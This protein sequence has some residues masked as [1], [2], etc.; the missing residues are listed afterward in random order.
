M[1]TKLRMPQTA[2]LRR[3]VEFQHGKQG[4]ARMLRR[5]LHGAKNWVLEDDADGMPRPASSKAVRVFIVLIPVWLVVSA[6]TGGPQRGGRDVGMGQAVLMALVLTLVGLAWLSARER[7]L[8]REEPWA[9]L[10]GAETEITE[11]DTDAIE[12]PVGPESEAPTDVFEKSQVEEVEPDEEDAFHADKN[13]EEEQSAQIATQPVPQATEEMINSLAVIEQTGTVGVVQEG[14]DRTTSEGMDPETRKNRWNA[15]PESSVDS[16]EGATLEVQS[17]QV[18]TD[19]EEDIETVPQASANHPKVVLTKSDQNDLPDTPTV[20]FRASFRAPFH[21]TEK[22][23]VGTVKEPSRGTIQTEFQCAYAERGPYPSK[24]DPVRDD[25]WLV[26]PDIETEETPEAEADPAPPEDLPD[27]WADPEP[28]TAEAAPG[29]AVA[30][31]TYPEVVQ[32]YFASRVSVDVGE[33]ERDSARDAVMEWAVAEVDEGRKSQSEVA[34]LLGI[35][36]AT[37]SRW[38]NAEADAEDVE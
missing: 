11:S 2:G 32:R 27:P 29:S 9:E 30:L 26:A 10:K 36:K 20:P 25:W 22:P 6:A 24:P 37:V 19:I 1:K 23:Q 28:V 5:G 21:G 4:T 13:E 34:R 15:P 8:G 14:F 7:K 31:Q 16:S 33:D 38:V 3:S 12:G 17:S 18:T 35:G